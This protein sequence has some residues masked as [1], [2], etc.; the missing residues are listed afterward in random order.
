MDV[1]PYAVDP[2]TGEPLSG[3][4]DAPDAWDYLETLHDSFVERVR[5]VL[6]NRGSAEFLWWLR[7][8]SGQ[9]DSVND[10]RSTGP[11]VQLIAEALATGLSRPASPVPNLAMFTFPLTA[12]VLWEL[13]WLSE[14]SI[15]MYR[16]HATMKRC[17]KGEAV[18]LIP[19]DVPRW[20][21]DDMLDDAIEEYDSRTER[22]SANIMQSVGVVAPA[23]TLS[24][25]HVSVG[26]LVPNWHATYSPKAR[27]FGK[28]E[29]L[30][31][32]FEWVDLDAVAPLREQQVLSRDHV[33]LIALLW[34]AFNIGTRD[35]EMTV[36]RMTAPV[37]WGYM[38]TPTENFLVRALD[39]MCSWMQEGSGKALAGC[40]VPRSASEI[41][42]VLDALQ[43]RVW[44]PLCG[45]PVHSAEEHS[46]ID[47][48][49]A[50]RRLFATLLRP[51]DGADVNVWSFHF[52]QNVQDAI[53]GTLWQP[54]GNVR[55]L[56]GRK[57]MRRDGSHMTDID[58]VAYRNRD[59]VLVS[60]K[61]LAF[62]VPALAGELSITRNIV[63][64]THAAA[65]QWSDVI[66]E[67]RDDPGLLPLNL[68][69][70]VRI[71]G[72]VAFPSVPFFTEPQW[73]FEVLDGV[74]YMVSVNELAKGLSSE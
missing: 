40:W 27:P 13:S 60:C 70:D 39:E 17:A 7:R 18:D 3:K 16:L 48:A 24:P 19:G 6:S 69:S 12:E 14:I 66:A 53:D 62:T 68:P 31:F 45:N 61:S 23:G 37:Q 52:E 47:L 4:I 57:V 50:S 71:S 67:L 30:P 28:H 35:P 65:S 25:Q 58:A 10:L 49:G 33:A 42:A 55:M 38:V 8:L 73:R 20:E 59:L 1:Y 26:G 64:K 74:P 56:I 15:L 46:V 5:D 36:Q 32:L 51:S 34:A 43:P 9:F 44:P 29:P 41:L 72:C 22:E 21:P 54:Q 11:Y 63:D 2:E